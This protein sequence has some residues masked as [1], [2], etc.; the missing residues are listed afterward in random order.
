MSVCVILYSFYE[1]PYFRNYSL[2]SEI[3]KI[4]E[5]SHKQQNVICVYKFVF[6]KYV[7]K[8]YTDVCN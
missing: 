7:L 5:V 4:P 1:K 2:H 6:L 3:F 8:I